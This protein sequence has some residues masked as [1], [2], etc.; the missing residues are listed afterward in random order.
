MLALRNAF[1]DNK[2][3]TWHGAYPWKTEE[4]GIAVRATLGTVDFVEVCERELELAGKAFDALAK[5]AIGKRR[6]LVEERLD[7]CGV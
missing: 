4:V 1:Q 7:D 2:W 3:Q 6:Q 5:L